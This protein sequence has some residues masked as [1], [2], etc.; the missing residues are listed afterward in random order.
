MPN[1]LMD[2]IGPDG[3]DLDYEG[4]DEYIPSFREDDETIPQR[5]IDKAVK[6]FWKEVDGESE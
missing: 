6:G 3:C 4:S 5:K 1:P 2:L